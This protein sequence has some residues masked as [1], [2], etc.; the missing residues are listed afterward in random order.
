M[1]VSLKHLTFEVLSLKHLTFE[2][3]SYLKEA[4]RSKPVRNLSPWSL[5][6][7]LP[8]GS[9]LCS[10]HWWTVMW[11][12]ELK[13]RY[14]SLPSSSW[15]WHFTTA[16]ETLRHQELILFSLFSPGKNDGKL[17]CYFQVSFPAS[18]PEDFSVTGKNLPLPGVSSHLAQHCLLCRPRVRKLWFR[19]MV[20]LPLEP[21]T[22]TGLCKV[23][24]LAHWEI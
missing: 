19:S 16:T 1:R 7:F 18:L 20:I 15:S 8:L 2:V 14:P 13:D 6:Q 21:L 10:L 3:L 9:C 23:R 5:H 12:D 24:L 11:K 22:A 17:C 4:I